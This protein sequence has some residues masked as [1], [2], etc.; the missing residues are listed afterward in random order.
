MFKVTY[1]YSIDP[2]QTN[3]T[4]VDTSTARSL[5]MDF[6]ESALADASC[7]EASTGVASWVVGSQSGTWCIQ[8]LLGDGSSPDFG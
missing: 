8:P 2:T 4:T 7:P 5:N 6:N 1:D 3:P